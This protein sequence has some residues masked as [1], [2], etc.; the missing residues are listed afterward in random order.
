MKPASVV[1]AVVLSVV[2]VACGEPAAIAEGETYVLRSI[3]GDLVPAVFTESDM[4]R[5]R[6]LADT[7]ELAEDHTGREVQHLETFTTVDGSLD[8]YRSVV[9]LTWSMRDGRMT[10]AYDCPDF[11]ACIE[12]PHLAGTATVT[13]VTFDFSLGR[14]PLVFERVLR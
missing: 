13:G 9:S 14:T 11:A 8:T 6:I 2:P 4:V 7:L 1:A 10:I 5:V 3:A 12:P